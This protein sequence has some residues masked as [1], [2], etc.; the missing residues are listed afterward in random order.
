MFIISTMFVCAECGQS[1]TPFKI[2]SYSILDLLG[3]CSRRCL[4]AFRGLLSPK[5][6]GPQEKVILPPTDGIQQQQ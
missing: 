3:L 6:T 2:T 5:Q 4:L 1:Y